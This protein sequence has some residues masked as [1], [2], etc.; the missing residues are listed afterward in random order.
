[1]PWREVEITVGGFP[2]NKPKRSISQG[3]RLGGVEASSPSKTIYHIWCLRTN[4][5]GRSCGNSVSSDV[6]TNPS[7]ISCIVQSKRHFNKL[8]FALLARKGRLFFMFRFYGSLDD[9]HK[10]YLILKKSYSVLASPTYPL[11]S[12]WDTHPVYSPR[13]NI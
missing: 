13:S 6:F 4:T 8:K 5:V 10:P 12:E 9:N 7:L 3:I 11:Y 2:P 1:M